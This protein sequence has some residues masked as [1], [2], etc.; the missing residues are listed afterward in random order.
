[1]YTV[2]EAIKFA[3]RQLSD[4]RRNREFTRWNRKDLLDYL[5]S[6]LKEIAAY[7]AEAF[8]SQTTIDLQP[9]IRQVLPEGVTVTGIVDTATG[10]P[11]NNADDT[12][13]KSFAGMN[14]C[15][16]RP[17]FVKG[18]AVYS[19]RSFAVDR[20]N[21]K[22]FYVSPAVPAGVAV[23][24]LATMEGKPPQYTFQDWNKPID[25]QD[26]FYNNLIDWMMARAYQ[27]DT[28]SQVS[29]SQARGLLQGFYSIM[30]VKYKMD[31]AR[32]SGYYEGKTGTGDPRAVAL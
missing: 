17:K 2:G 28:E 21:P 19:P 12:L 23:S 31:S 25:M 8:A 16:S 20:D 15:P 30:G 13:L 14:P 29:L 18:I 11:V 22:V 7:R 1:M 10:M 27:M 32:S 6:G 5:N 3:S 4:Q 24:V 9:G 26:K